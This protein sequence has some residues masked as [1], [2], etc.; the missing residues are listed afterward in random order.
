M[1]LDQIVV[2]DEYPECRRLQECSGLEQ[3]HIVADCKGTFCP[4]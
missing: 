2:D 3:L 1:T 4:F